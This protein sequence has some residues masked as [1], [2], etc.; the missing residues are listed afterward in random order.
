MS[1]ADRMFVGVI[2]L[3]ALAL[4]GAT[5][6]TLLDNRAAR[7]AQGTVHLTLTGGERLSIPT[8]GRAALCTHR[9]AGNAGVRVTLPDGRQ[10]NGSRI[11]RASVTNLR[12]ADVFGRIPEPD[13]CDAAL[14]G[15]KGAL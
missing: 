14:L 15:M 12:T 8:E 3:I 1:A 7:N 6:V 9:W 11:E 4:G 13:G 5:G 2:L 10:V